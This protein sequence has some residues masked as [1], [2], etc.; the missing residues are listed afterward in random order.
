MRGDKIILETPSTAAII[1]ALPDDNHPEKQAPYVSPGNREMGADEEPVERAIALDV[2]AASQAVYSGWTIPNGDG[3][4]GAIAQR[5]I[6]AQVSAAVTGRKPL[7]FDPWGEEFS[8]AFAQSYRKVIP[9][10]VEVISREGMLFV[11][12]PE[13]VTPILD[14]DPDFYRHAG[15]SIID[16]IARV[17]GQGM[18]G[19][20]LGYGARHMQENPAHE[21]KIYKGSDL[22]LYFFVSDP[23]EILAEKIAGERANDFIRAFGWG[24]VSFELTKRG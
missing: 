3:S 23:D 22:V 12:R 1:P 9:S 11:Y 10:D 8:D 20:L 18:N 6:E 7:Y 21:V 17:S 15:E 24:D 2:R 5:A 16:S 19:E 14:S 4:P 13:A